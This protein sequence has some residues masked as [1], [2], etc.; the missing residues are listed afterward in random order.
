MSLCIIPLWWLN[1]IPLYIQ[2]YCIL[3]IHPQLIDVQV[4]STVCL[5]SAMLLNAFMHKFSC[6]HIFLVLWCIPRSGLLGHTVILCFMFWGTLGL[7]IL[8]PSPLSGLLSPVSIFP[9]NPG[10]SSPSLD[11]GL[12]PCTRRIVSVGYD[13]SSL[14]PLLTGRQP[15]GGQLCYPAVFSP[16]LAGWGASQALSPLPP[17][18]KK[19]CV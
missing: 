6:G 12:H 1:N 18:V 13:Y 2:I 8:N 11:L 17:A 3:F 5:W 19:M 4:V 7:F 10:P 14:W 15:A 9:L 16:T